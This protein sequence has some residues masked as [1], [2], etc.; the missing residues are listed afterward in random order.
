MTRVESNL[1]TRFARLTKARP[2]IGPIL[3]LKPPINRS[4]TDCFVV[5]VLIK[6]RVFHS[7]TRPKKERK[8][9]DRDG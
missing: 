9:R 2:N 4:K 1:Y 5:P 6:S 7:N 8:H 3:N